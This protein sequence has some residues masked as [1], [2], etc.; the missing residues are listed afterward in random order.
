MPT[1]YTANSK[2]AA[3]TKAILGAYKP[4]CGSGSGS[5]SSGSG[6]GG[7][8]T[9]PCCG[10]DTY[11]ADISVSWDVACLDAGTAVLTKVFASTN[12]TTA[13][14][15]VQYNYTVTNSTS[16]DF[17][18][19]NRCSDNTAIGVSNATDTT[20]FSV[21]CWACE[22]NGVMT[23]RWEFVI[24]LRRYNGSTFYYCY[25][26]IPLNLVSCSPFSFTSLSGSVV[27]D[28]SG[29]AGDCCNT[30]YEEL[31]TAYTNCEGSAYSFDIS[32]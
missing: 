7:G 27:C 29:T 14:M 17:L 32:E 12:C 26:R 15:K 19:A 24:E 10:C 5:G 3:I 31:L 21:E 6:G 2:S 11:P 18:F 25:S 4:C 9:E 22:I 1:V 16:E 30:C 23:H 28:D 13:G 20:T 8:G